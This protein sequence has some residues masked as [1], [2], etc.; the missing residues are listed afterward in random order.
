MTAKLVPLVATVRHR[1]YVEVFGGGASLLFA[2]TPA[3]VEVYNDLDSGL[4][5]LFRVI[6]DPR[7]FKQFYRLVSFTPWSREEYHHCCATWKECE[8]QV[9]RAYRFFVVARMSFGGI[10]GNS[11]GFSLTSSSRYM[12]MTTSSWLSIIDMLPEISRRLMQV[13]IEHLDWRRCLKLYDTLESFFYL[14][15]PYAPDTRRGGQYQHEMT[16]ED[17]KELINCLLKLQGKCLLS[18]YSSPIY[19]SLDKAGWT[20]LEFPTACSAVGR[21]R[22]SGILGVGSALRMQSRTEV[23][24]MN[25]ELPTRVATRVRENWQRTLEED[26]CQKYPISE[27]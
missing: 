9:E 22:A 10:F 3:P 23:V 17:H 7:L 5:N 15:P 26:S 20:R 25:Y 24:W 14:D 11:F 6:R 13:Q 12:S 27:I 2:K 8:D 4:V 19:D 21:T 1:I 18:G 16:E